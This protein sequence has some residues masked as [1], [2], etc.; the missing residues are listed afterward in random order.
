MS[1]R[2][3]LAARRLPLT[4]PGPRPALGKR[5][6]KAGKAP[7]ER[8]CGGEVRGWQLAVGSW[9]MAVGH[10]TFQHHRWEGRGAPWAGH[11]EQLGEGRHGQGLRGAAPAAQ[12][13]GLGSAQ[14]LLR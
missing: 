1:E 5:K 12:R 3:K 4:L 7:V 11:G 9:S 8:C 14:P 6:G 2:C 13:G 10:W